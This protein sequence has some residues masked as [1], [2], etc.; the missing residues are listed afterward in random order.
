MPHPTAGSV[1]IDGL[2]AKAF[3]HAGANGFPSTPVGEH[4]DEVLRSC[5]GYT[6]DEIMRL[7]DNGVI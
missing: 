1:K 5:L 6:S 7:R 4:T 3:P 2:A